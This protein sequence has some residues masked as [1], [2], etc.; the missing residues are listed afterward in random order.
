M[1]QDMIK[2]YEERATEYDL[3]YQIPEEQPDLQKATNLFQEIVAGKNV[4]E[5]ACGTGFWTEA[6]AQTA[7]SVYATD[8]NQRVIHIAQQRQVHKNISYHVL[9]MHQIQTDKKWDILFGGFI[10]SHLLLQE[11]PGFLQKLHSII[12][13]DGMFIFIDSKQKEN[14][15]HDAKNIHRTDKFGNTFQCRT[16]LNGTQ[17]EVVK[18]FPS[19]A[20]LKEQFSK[21]GY[22]IQFVQLD[23]YWI[24]SCKNK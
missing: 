12:N 7:H 8:I 13:R 5:I 14:S 3:V 15:V 16:L 18:N 20:F 6:M 2:Y 21:I 10:W 11:I 23:Y 19:S 1:N 17:H 22:D 9:D 24:L 4:V